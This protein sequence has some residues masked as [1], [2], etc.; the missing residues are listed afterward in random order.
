MYAI[1]F[2]PFAM[3]CDSPSLYERET[4]CT[5]FIAEFP[6]VWD[7]TVALDSQFG[8]YVA[9]ARRSG[10]I[11]Y[12]GVM[13]DWTPRKVELDLSKFLGEGNYVAEVFRDGVNADKLGEDY[14]HEVVNVPSSR[15]MVAELAPAGG[16][17]LKIT[18]K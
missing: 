6:T 17:V 18:K 3:L 4:E 10:D 1:Y 14:I 8:D 12:V 7:E 13:G 16:Y 11:W 9:M 2:S 15:K 5:K